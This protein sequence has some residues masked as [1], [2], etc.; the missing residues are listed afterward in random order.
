MKE[1]VKDLIAEGKLE[2]AAVIITDA[3]RGLLSHS[4][5][6]V[7]LSRDEF[8]KVAPKILYIMENGIPKPDPTEDPGDD[9]DINP[10]VATLTVT[11]EGPED[12]DEFEE[13]P[14]F[15]KNVAV[16][17]SYSFAPYTVVGY[18]P[19]KTLIEGKMVKTGVTVKVTYAKE[20]PPVPVEKHTLTITYVGPVGDPDWTAPAEYTAELE[21]GEEYMVISP[22][23]T[24]Y[25]P[26]K[27]NVSGAMATEDV[28]VTVTYSKNDPTPTPKHTLTIDYVGP[29]GDEEF[30]A[31]DGY[32]AELAEGEEFMV[33]SPEVEGYLPDKQ[34][35]SGV[36][37]TEDIDEVVTYTKA[38]TTLPSSGSDPIVEEEEEP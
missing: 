26:D 28:A 21:E 35:V 3:L 31:P 27:A 22:E 5:L 19:D 10:A 8:F 33:P 15:V 14:A 13:L 1:S 25:T 23:V 36:M 2:A 6:G 9:I 29:E 34:S 7:D 18:T 20:E 24:G 12:D 30:V 37:A 11:F 16:G 17:A 38:A 32:I 4:A